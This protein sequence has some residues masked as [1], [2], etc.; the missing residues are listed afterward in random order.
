MFSRV[1]RAWPRI[2]RAEAL[3]RIDEL[4]QRIELLEASRKGQAAQLGEHADRLPRLEPAVA[5]HQLRLHQLELQAQT[6]ARHLAALE[7]AIIK[8]QRKPKRKRPGA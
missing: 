2:S 8:L 7:A 4:A 6:A 1:R 3:E 5:E